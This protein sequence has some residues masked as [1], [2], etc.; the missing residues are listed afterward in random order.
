[1]DDVLGYSRTFF[2]GGSYRAP[3]FLYFRVAIAHFHET[4]ADVARHSELRT[5][6]R[7]VTPQVLLQGPCRHFFSPAVGLTWLGGDIGDWKRSSL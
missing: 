6:L 1:M 5:K 2:I 3:E 4:R 7:E